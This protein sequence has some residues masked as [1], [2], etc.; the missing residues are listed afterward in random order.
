MVPNFK[1]FQDKKKKK[2]LK[3]IFESKESTLAFI[4]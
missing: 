4:F 1:Y 3:S 2:N